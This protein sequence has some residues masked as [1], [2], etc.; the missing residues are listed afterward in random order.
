MSVVRRSAGAGLCV[1]ASM[2]SGGAAGL[3]LGPTVH[4]AGAA[5]RGEVDWLADVY[6]LGA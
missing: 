4:G 5:R 2:G 6:S 3:V 1:G